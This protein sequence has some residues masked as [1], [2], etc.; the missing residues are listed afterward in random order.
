MLL[1]LHV[2]N[3]ALIQQADVEFGEGLNILTGETGAGKSIIIGSVNL[4]LGEKARSD[5]IRSGAEYAYVELVFAITP[6]KAAALKELDIIPDEDGILVISRKI[7]P[8][9]SVSKV[10]GETVTAARLK[11]ITGLLIDIHGQHEHQSLFYP[12]RHLEILDTYAKSQTEQLK[13]QVARTYHT[14][15]KLSTELQKASL[16]QESRKR[17]IDFLQ[18]EID[19][20]E[21]A[22][23]REGEEERLTEQYRRYSHGRKI[24]ESLAAA[25]EALEGA[26]VGRALYQVNEVAEYDQRLQAIRDQLYDVEAIISDV[27]R[28]ITSYQDEVVFDEAE[29]LQIEERL[30]LIHNLQAKYGSSVARIQTS[31]NEKKERLEQLEHFDEFRQQL[32]AELKNTMDYLDGLSTTLSLERQKAAS[33]LTGLIR[34]GLTDLNFLDVSYDMEFKKLDHYTANGFDAAEFVIS[35]NPGEPMRPLAL[36]ASGGELSRIMLAIKTVLADSDDIPTLIFD[37]IDTGISGR[38]AQKVSEKLSIISRNH[39]VI[40][41]THLPQI[42]AM[43]DHHFEI[44]KAVSDGKTATNIQILNENQSI[45]ELARLLSGAEVTETVLKNA[46][47]MK[48]LANLVS[49]K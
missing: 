45:T 30:D 20:I 10:N 49:K 14:Y 23:L 46:Q 35:T 17:E 29:L 1:E 11:Q 2:K 24:M 21:Q 15:Q 12:V 31:L 44:A 48:R 33:Q 3:L 22:A 37:E 47:E 4:A 34:S 25:Y 39:Q 42:A 38:T 36:V 18:F 9:R 19:E 16:D 7:M 5:I 8:A 26:E 40:C 28:E 27:T 41:I 6:E 32:E 43:A 13:T